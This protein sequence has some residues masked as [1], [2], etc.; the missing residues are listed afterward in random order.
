MG[1]VI[2]FS[3]NILHSE[4]STWANRISMSSITMV[5]Y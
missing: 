3:G 2:G 4:S 1:G 5:A